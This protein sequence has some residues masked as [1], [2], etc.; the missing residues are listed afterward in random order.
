LSQ[1]P[2]G[3]YGQQGV[4]NTSNVPSGKMG[5]ISWIDHDGNLWLFGGNKKIPFSILSM[6]DVWKYIP[7]TSCFGNALFICDV[8][9]APA[10]V[11]DQAEICQKFCTDFIDQSTNE[12]TAWQWI[13]EGGSPPTSNEQNPTNICYNEPGS[14]DVTLIT[15]SV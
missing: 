11:A 9:P 1:S 8:V 7:D 15:T 13:F 6:N 4:S 5:P 2:G 14:F 12:P 10:F 3:F